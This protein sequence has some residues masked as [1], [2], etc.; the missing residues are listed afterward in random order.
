MKASFILFFSTFFLKITRINF[1]QL[2]LDFLFLFVALLTWVQKLVVKLLPWFTPPIAFYQKWWAGAGRPNSTLRAPASFISRESFPF[3]ICGARVSGGVGVSGVVERV[4]AATRAAFPTRRRAS[5]VA[6][7]RG[8]ARSSPTSGAG[9]LPLTRRRPI[10]PRP[11][12]AGAEM[13]WFPALLLL[14]LLLFYYIT[15]V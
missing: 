12:R 10:S 1:S 4:T 5:P 13:H 14:L 15:F 8:A 3:P 7:P 9:R 2:L 11:S 6:P